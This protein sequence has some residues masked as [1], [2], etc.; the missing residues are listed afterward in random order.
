M[1]HGFRSISLDR[2]LLQLE[3]YS[4][5]VPIFFNMLNIS[6]AINIWLI[7]PILMMTPA[8]IY[9]ILFNKMPSINFSTHKPTKTDKQK[10]VA[11][12]I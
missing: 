4:Q 6:Y 7:S 8:I 1:F 12:Y 5:I 9:K 2:V 3:I 10:Q 11:S